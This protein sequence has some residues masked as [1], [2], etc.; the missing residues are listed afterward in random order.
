MMISLEVLIALFLSAVAVVALTS[1]AHSLRCAWIK[2][3]EL[4]LASRNPHLDT[5]R[6]Q[7]RDLGVRAEPKV[8]QL[9]PFLGKPLRPATPR[10]L[11]VAA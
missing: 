10:A 2:A 6:V 7:W 5:V 1:L 9:R 3:E 4:A 8:V 11:R